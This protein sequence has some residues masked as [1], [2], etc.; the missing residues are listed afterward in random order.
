LKS[1]EE[2]LSSDFIRINRSCIINLQ[3]VEQVNFNQLTI[4]SVTMKTNETFTTT[5]Q[6]ASHLKDA[7]SL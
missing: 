1:I 7:L 4:Q 6:T 3:H 2:K 5:Q